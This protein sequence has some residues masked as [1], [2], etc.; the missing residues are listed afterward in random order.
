MTL[1]KAQGCADSGRAERMVSNL[2]WCL[3]GRGGSDGMT[4]VKGCL[5]PVMKDLPCCIQAARLSCQLQNT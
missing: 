5:G 1:P 2:H 3:S 4:Q